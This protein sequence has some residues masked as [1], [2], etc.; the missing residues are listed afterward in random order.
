MEKLN[1]NAKAID[2][3]FDALDDEFSNLSTNLSKTVSDMYMEVHNIADQTAKTKG[4]VD[5]LTTKVNDLDSK[6]KSTKE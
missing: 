5:K 1:V 6:L 3:K 2:G 4:H